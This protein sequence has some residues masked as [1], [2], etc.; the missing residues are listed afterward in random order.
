MPRDW[1][2]SEWLFSL[3]SLP[4]SISGRLARDTHDH[5]ADRRMADMRFQFEDSWMTFHDA[6]DSVASSFSPWTRSAARGLGA[7]R[8]GSSLVLIALR[9]ASA[10]CSACLT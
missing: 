10:S 9:L 8:S 7:I 3:H 2:W 1:H 4:L 5:A 6:G